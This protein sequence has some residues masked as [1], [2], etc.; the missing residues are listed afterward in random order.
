MIGED[1][2]SRASENLFYS[3]TLEQRIDGLQDQI[4]LMCQQMD[5]KDIELVVLGR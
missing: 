5:D 3:K 2:R 1:F 4:K